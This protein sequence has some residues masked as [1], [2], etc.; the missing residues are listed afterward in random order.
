MKA[1]SEKAPLAKRLG[2]LLLIWAGSVAAL[3]VAAW[4]M[5]LLMSAAGLG[6]PH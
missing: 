2:W 1:Q 6:A 3:G 5:R 4:L